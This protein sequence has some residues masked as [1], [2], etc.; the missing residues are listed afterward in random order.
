MKQ[1]T[2][3]RNNTGQSLDGI[4]LINKHQSVTSNR[5]IQD[6]KK[7]FALNKIGHC[8][9]LDPMAT[10]LMIL[11]LDKG[12]KVARYLTG[13]DK[14]YL[15]VVKLGEETDTDDRTGSIIKS[16]DIQISLQYLKRV[17]EGFTG[18][19]DQIPP[20]YSAIKVSGKRAYKVARNG[21]S[22]EL[23][24]RKVTIESCDLI[25]YENKRVT[26]RI[27]CSKGTYIRSIARDL[28]RQLGSYGHLD[29]LVREA[30]GDY[31]LSDSRCIQDYR[32][33][34]QADFQS[35]C[36]DLNEALSFMPNLLVDDSRAK[37]VMMGQ[38]LS[39]TMID[40]ELSRDYPFHKVMDP[41]GRVLAVVD[42]E[43][44]Y[45]NVFQYEDI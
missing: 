32:D 1:N 25:D 19:I 3:T 5:L 9:T 24:A 8:G 23:S 2:L 21:S 34:T 22:V 11:C 39:Q 20:Q 42:Y 38:T 41:A 45:Q 44:N 26:L 30:I 7:R 16:S 37:K 28:G 15:A 35:K 4:V 10:G 31:T 12:T 14:Q 40:G 18:E 27:K 36:L 13:L 43:L 29:S 6:V 17:L 33:I